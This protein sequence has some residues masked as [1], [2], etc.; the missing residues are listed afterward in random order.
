[1]NAVTPLNLLRGANVF[2]RTRDRRQWRREVELGQAMGDWIAWSQASSFRDLGALTANWL[3]GVLPTQPMYGGGPDDETKP[4]IGYLAA[5]NRA[6]FVT[7]GSQPGTPP[8]NGWAQ[9]AWVE[10]WCTEATAR[11]IE[12]SLLG[13]DLIVGYTPPGNT[14]WTRICIT[15][16]GGQPNTT[17]CAMTRDYLIEQY[18]EALP[19]AMPALVNAWQVYVIDPRWG[20][21]DLLWDAL[22][23]AL[24]SPVETAPALLQMEA[25]P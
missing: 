12:N 16:G 15:I 13:T 24:A 25:T 11:Q 2:R 4:L 21:N 3:E 7:H 20:R 6:G 1:M 9:R 23:G 5:Y 19:A 14:A 8:R 18:R 22:L 17:A 10:G